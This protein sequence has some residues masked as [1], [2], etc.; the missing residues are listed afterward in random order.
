MIGAAWILITPMLMLSVFTLV[1]HGVFGT[2]WPGAKTQSPLEFA[3]FLFAGLMLFQFLADVITRAPS[4]VVSQ[5]NYVTKIVF[6]LWLMPLSLTLSGLSQLLVN[7]ALLTGLI[8]FTHG[9]SWYWLWQPVILLPLVGM[10]AGCAWIL[11]ALGVYARDTAPAINM[12]TTLLMFLSPIF[13]PVA[14][15]P[16]EWRGIFMLNPLASFIEQTRGVLLL[17]TAPDPTILLGL[18]LM[19]VGTMGLGLW[20]FTKLQRGFADVI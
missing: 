7:T 14:S 18:Y 17:G 20:L 8:A 6:P 19:G 11:A 9:G 5:P 2:R 1:F 10:T 13:F 3:L 16:E 15:V 12:L 4:L